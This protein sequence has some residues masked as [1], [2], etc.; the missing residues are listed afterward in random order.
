M[1]LTD[2][3]P[4]LNQLNGRMMEQIRCL[5]DDE[6]TLCKQILV[7]A[8]QTYQPPKLKELACFA[9][10]LQD[11]TND[12]ASL[13]EIVNL[14]GSLLT[15]REDTI[16]FV[17]QSAKYYLLTHVMD[18][19]YHSG[20]EAVHYSIFLKSLEIISKTLRRDV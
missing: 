19:I 8:G 18:E 9:D 1:I 14:C 15:V 12:P 13:Q 2:S 10:T 3:Q 20:Q 16:Y 7:V 5:D 17:H 4:G 11:V 6:S